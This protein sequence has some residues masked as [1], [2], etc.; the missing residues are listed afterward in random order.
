[1]SKLYTATE[2]ERMVANGQSLDSLPPDAR[3]TP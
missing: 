3:L 1:M 2:L